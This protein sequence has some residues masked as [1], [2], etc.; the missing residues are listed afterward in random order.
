MLMKLSKCKQ[1]YKSVMPSPT[2]DAQLFVFSPTFSG[3]IANLCKWLFLIIYTGS[4]PATV[5]HLFHS[6]FK[7]ETLESHSQEQEGAL[8]YS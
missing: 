3:L 8:Q 2:K 6:S 7:N 5:T 1:T 4:L